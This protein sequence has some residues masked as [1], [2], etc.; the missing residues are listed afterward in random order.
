[1]RTTGKVLIIEAPTEADIELIRN[2]ESVK[3]H[4][5]CELPKKRKPLVIMYD[6]PT[7]DTE[8]KVVDSIY[9]Q[10][11]EETTTKED[12]ERDFEVKFKTGPRGKSTVHY[13]VEVSPEMRKLLIKNRTYIGFTSV[14]SKD[15]LVVPRCMRCNDLGHVSKH[16]TRQT[17]CSH[18]G[19]EHER[20]ECTKTG[21]PRN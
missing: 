2:N 1:M 16:C 17:A 6:V 4:F 14:N 8:Q 3:E 18:C 21:Q 11:F 20:K 7:H 10:N 13:V 15:Y 19:E 12:F 5:K 9:T